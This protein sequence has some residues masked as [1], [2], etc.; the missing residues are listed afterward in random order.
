MIR[1]KKTYSVLA[2]LTE[3]A[4]PSEDGLL[5]GEGVGWMK[6]VVSVQEGSED[7]GDVSDRIGRGAP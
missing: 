7:L 3:D 2:G 4:P 5:A 1:K 6:A